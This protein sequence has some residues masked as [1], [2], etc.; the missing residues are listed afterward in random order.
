MRE[1]FAAWIDRD[2]VRASGP[3]AVAFLQGQLSQDVE[4]LA[5][6][7][8]TWSLLL[9]PSG[10]VDSWL[11]VTREAQDVMVLDV[12]GGWGDALVARLARFK[13]RT[14][15]DLEPVDGWRG[16]A[17][18]NATLAPS[19]AGD[20]GNGVAHCLPIV[21]PGTDGY[22]LLG[23]DVEPPTGV[24]ISDPS[25]ATYER[26]RI[27]AGVPAL[28]HE[29]T[30]ATIPVEAGQWLIDASVS[31]TK[32]CFTGQ[33]LVARIDSRGGS[34]PRPV[35][36]LRIA[37]AVVRGDEIVRGGDTIGS[38]TSAAETDDGSTVAL[39]PLSRTVALGSDVEVAGQA[40][41]VVALPMA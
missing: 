14:K 30:E 6:G 24:A 18:R 25:A 37:G 2:V 27:E 13:L 12:D 21:W 15:C 29:L 33:E 36:G 39:A 38:L 22:D 4:S 1:P 16:V 7:H 8:S 28:G 26:A 23:L 35:R 17:V 9:Q 11:R 10:K 19:D 20:A 32:G 34:A 41:R 31:F 5:I 3:D 40:G